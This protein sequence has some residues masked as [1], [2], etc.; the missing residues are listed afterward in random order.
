MSPSDSDD[1]PA[2]PVIRTLAEA[3]GKGDWARID[4]AWDRIRIPR[5]IHLR[6]DAELDADA[7]LL[8]AFG[9][10]QHQ[11]FLVALIRELIL[12]DLLTDDDLRRISR[13]PRGPE[14]KMHAFLNGEY[15]PVNALLEGKNLVAACDHV[16]RIDIDGDQVGTGVQI[17]PRLVATAAHVI[18]TLIA[19][20][21]DGQAGPRAREPLRPADDSLGRLSV[22]FC[23]AEDFTDDEGLD[24]RRLAGEVASLHPLWLAG[25][26][27][28]RSATTLHSAS[29]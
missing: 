5:G 16:C 11:G 12:E 22:T 20:P 24:T 17:S 21:P 28:V 14:W 2:D 29:L 8:S 27:G 23:D 26:A 10:A 13:L 25:E 4:A 15:L 7:F 18:E 3:V 9:I 6:R 1:I 19:P